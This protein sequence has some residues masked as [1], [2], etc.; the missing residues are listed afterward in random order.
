MWG[1]EWIEVAHVRDR[2]REHVNAVLN[3]RVPKF[4]GIS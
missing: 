1:M 4:R 2:S 3:F